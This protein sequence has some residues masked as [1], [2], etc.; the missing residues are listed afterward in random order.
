MHGIREVHCHSE[1]H[2]P[3]ARPGSRT[4]ALAR[5]AH[6]LK[7]H[8]PRPTSCSHP[9][10]TLRVALI[11]SR[12]PHDLSAPVVQ[13]AS[14]FVLALQR[15]WTPRPVRVA[16]RSESLQQLSFSHI[17]LYEVVLTH[18]TL[19]CLVASNKNASL[20]GSSCT[21]TAGTLTFTGSASRCA[22]F[23][24]EVTMKCRRQ[25]AHAFP[26]KAIT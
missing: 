23:A 19:C 25:L 2:V 9:Q 5:A 24:Q 18:L 16:C 22:I 26:V 3:C 4:H 14:L 10:Q 13:A 21:E 6:S 8:A 12:G 17:S 1:A 15:R 11:F 20:I 7:Q